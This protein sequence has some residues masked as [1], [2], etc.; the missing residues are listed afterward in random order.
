VKVITSE[1]RVMVGRVRYV[2][3]VSG[4]AE[5]HV[6][7]ELPQDTGDSDGVFQGHRY[8]DW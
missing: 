4:K 6:G 8:F 5:P 1:G 3:L 7:V 2:G